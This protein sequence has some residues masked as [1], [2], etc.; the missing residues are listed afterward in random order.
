[1]HTAPPTINFKYYTVHNNKTFNKH[2]VNR[3]LQLKAHFR[4]PGPYISYI[5]DCHKITMDVKLISWQSLI[6]HPLCTGCLTI[7]WYFFNSGKKWDLFFVKTW[8]YFEEKFKMTQ[9]RKSKYFH[10]RSIV[11]GPL[12]ESMTIFFCYLENT[13]FKC[14]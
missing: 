14:E 12:L 6:Y 13:F 8:S 11:Q 4:T 5:K 10:F 2:E 9:K 7:K 1:M 3:K